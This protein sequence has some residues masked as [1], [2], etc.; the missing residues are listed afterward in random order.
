MKMQRMYRIAAILLFAAIAMAVPKFAQAANTAAGVSISNQATVDYTV[1]AVPQTQ[2]LGN[3]VTFV[4]DRV[5]YLTV[6]KQW[7]VTSSPSSTFQAIGF[8]VTN[9]SNTAIRFA[10][11]SV[12]TGTW[13]LT[14]PDIYRDNNNNGKYDAGETK[15]VDASTFGDVASGASLTV[16]IVG[17][18]P[19]GLTN[20]V[21]TG[22]DLVATAVDMGTTNVSAQ[23]GGTKT[24]ANLNV[25]MTIW[26]DGAGT[27]AGDGL[28]DGK[29][30]ARGTFTVTAAGLTVNKTATVYSDPINLVSVNAKAIPGAVITYTVTVTNAAG[31]ANATNAV[32][33][34]NLNAMIT[35]GNIAIGDPFS[36]ASKTCIAGQI[37]VISTDGGVSWTCQNGTWSGGT[38]TLTESGLTVNAGNDVRIKYQVTIK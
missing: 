7:D 22:Y 24:G 19:A 35:A 33:T 8:L 27:A 26:G 10:L 18:I 37:S 5:I 31:G 9:N 12:N 29:H 28:H 16:M 32:I 14:T 17:D 38:N 25:V 6:T 11:S 15:Y 13:S 2:V 36:D 4:V 20:G 23:T 1:G 3:T 34:D 30:S 21:A